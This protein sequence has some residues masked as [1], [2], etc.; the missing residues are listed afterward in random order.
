M[1]W[2]TIHEDA[3]TDESLIQ[4]GFDSINRYSKV[5]SIIVSTTVAVKYITELSKK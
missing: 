3:V 4:V 5:V 2:K 1:L